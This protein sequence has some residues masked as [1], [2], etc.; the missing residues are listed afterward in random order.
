MSARGTLALA[1]RLELDRRRAPDDHA[2]TEADVQPVSIAR[3][4]GQDPI[5]A[6]HRALGVG[7][8]VPFARERR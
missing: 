6:N 3:T 7:R 5:A 2:R 1:D 4:A 8:D